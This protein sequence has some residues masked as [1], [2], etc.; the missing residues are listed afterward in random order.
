MV[1]VLQWLITGLTVVILADVLVSFILDPFHPV[2]RTLDSIVRPMLIP[3]R[4][5]LPPTGMLDFSPFVLLILVQV[6]GALVIR[7]LA[8]G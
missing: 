3:I 6:V 2:R 7:I 1:G 8:S 5:I 4:R